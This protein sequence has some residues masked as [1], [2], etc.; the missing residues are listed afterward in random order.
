MFFKLEVFVSR[1]IEVLLT[2]SFYT[3]FTFGHGHQTYMT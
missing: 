2:V 3:E 1:I